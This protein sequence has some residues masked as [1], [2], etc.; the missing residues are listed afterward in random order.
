MQLA[1]FRTSSPDG[2]LIVVSRDLARMA[3]ATSIAPTLKP[4]SI[5]GT[6]QRRSSPCSM[7]C[8]M[9]QKRNNWSVILLTFINQAENRNSGTASS[10]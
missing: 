4:R 7:E 8:S 6:R 2:E 3:R 10:T 1:T 5:V 9:S